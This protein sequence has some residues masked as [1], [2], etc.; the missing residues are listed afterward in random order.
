MLDKGFYDLLQPSRVI[1]NTN[2]E[3]RSM[4]EVG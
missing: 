4:A 1:H 3:Q 2:K